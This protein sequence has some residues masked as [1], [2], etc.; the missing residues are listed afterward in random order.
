MS[1]HEHVADAF[2]M[3]DTV[4]YN[5]CMEWATPFAIRVRDRCRLSNSEHLAYNLHDQTLAGTT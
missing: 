1:T 2:I 3:N 4:S 5:G